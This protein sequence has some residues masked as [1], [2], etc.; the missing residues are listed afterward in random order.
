MAEAI[1]EVLFCRW[2]KNFSGMGECP[3]ILT[4][5]EGHQCGFPLYEGLN[6]VHKD[7]VTILDEVGFW[8]KY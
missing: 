1:E 8:R 2:L 3:K 5:G 6:S 7:I 4:G